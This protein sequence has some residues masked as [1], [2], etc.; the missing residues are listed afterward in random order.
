MKS[1]KQYCEQRD[2]QEVAAAPDMGPPDAYQASAPYV[3][4]ADDVSQGIGQALRQY[5]VGSQAS[6]AELQ[7][8]MQDVGHKVFQLQHI[9]QQGGKLTPAQ[10][11]ELEGAQDMFKQLYDMHYRA[12]LKQDSQQTTQK[13]NT[14][15][16]GQT[17]SAGNQVQSLNSILRKSLG[18]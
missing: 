8:A 7:Q 4:A 18:N 9:E 1:F 5:G 14:Y 16:S 3:R 6:P 12:Q 15:K 2:L 17:D 11:K 10:Q 13:L